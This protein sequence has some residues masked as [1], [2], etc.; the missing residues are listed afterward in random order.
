MNMLGFD[1][2]RTDC[3]VVSYGCSSTKPKDLE[4]GTG[5]CNLGMNATIARS[6][7]FFFNLTKITLS[8][9]CVC[10]YVCARKINFSKKKKT[11]LKEK[12]MLGKKKKETKRTESVKEI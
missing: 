3:R 1:A 5:T 2:I 4:R 11:F 10:V 8:F 12:I 9:L 7:F 6:N